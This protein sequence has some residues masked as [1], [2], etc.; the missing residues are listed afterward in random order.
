MDQIG[1]DSNDI[2]SKYAVAEHKEHV[3]TVFGRDMSRWYV[4]LEF[5]GAQRRELAQLW[6]RSQSEMIVGEVAGVAALVMVVLAGAYGVMKFD[7][8][9]KGYYTRRLL[10]GGALATIVVVIAVAVNS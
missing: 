3:T 2:W 5:N 9:T 4:L 10:I 6:R 7:T 1:L 8:V